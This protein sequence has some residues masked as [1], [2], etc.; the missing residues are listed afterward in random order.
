M[1]STFGREISLANNIC[2]KHLSK[3]IENLSKRKLFQSI[4]FES[5]EGSI[6]TNEFKTNYIHA[7]P[8]GQYYIGRNMKCDIIGAP[9]TNQI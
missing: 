2:T 9:S 8:L 5:G 3:K 6:S 7:F 1:T 4:I